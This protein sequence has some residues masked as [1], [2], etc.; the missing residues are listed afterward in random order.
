MKVWHYFIH[1]S[2]DLDKI[3]YRE[4]HNA[5]WRTRNFSKIGAVKPHF[6]GDLNDFLSAVSMFLFRLRSNWYKTA[7]RD[8]LGHCDF[9]EH[10]RTEGRTARKHV[11]NTHVPGDISNV[12]NTVVQCVCLVTECQQKMLHLLTFRITVLTVRAS[13]FNFWTS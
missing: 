2:T 13:H 9:G 3:W 7:K 8:A 10:R 1:Y 11:N 5:Y 12:Q 4:S 6:L